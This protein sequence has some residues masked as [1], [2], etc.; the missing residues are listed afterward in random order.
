MNKED[1]LKAAQNNRRTG[2]EY[3]NKEG[4][5][6]GMLGSLIALLVGAVLFFIEY[7]CLKR[8]NCGLL[9]VAFSGAGADNLF[10][11]IRIR[12]AGS[13]ILGASELIIALFLLLAAIW[14]VVA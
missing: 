11:G 6:S 9:A 2:N 13:I 4:L 1:I 5:R 3:E 12:K 8:V 10:A 7:F 14:Q